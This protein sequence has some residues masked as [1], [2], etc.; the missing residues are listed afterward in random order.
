MKKKILIALVVYSLCFLLGGIYIISTIGASTSKLS[1]LIKLYQVETQRKQLLIRIKNV[2]TDLHLKRTPHSKSVETIIDNVKTMEQMS[3]TCFKCH[4]SEF[5][6]KRLLSLRN[7]IED[8]KYLISRVLTLRANRAR[9]KS[10]D[11]KASFKAEQLL[12]LVD[13]MV[14]QATVRLSETTQFSLN[15]ISKSNA[16]L[17]VLVGLTPIFAAMLGFIFIRGLTNPVKELLMAT[18][19][20]KGGD[21]DHRI[22]GLQD[23]FGEVAESFNEMAG[24]VE[25]YTQRLEGQA[26]ELERAHS[27]MSTFCQVLK[28]IGV[29]QTLEGVGTFL[30]EEFEGILNTQ[31][32]Q[33]YIFSSD[34]NT[35][36][37][38]SDK[39]ADTI[40][41][42]E[43]VQ[44]SAIAIAKLDKR[45][46]SPQSPFKPPLLPDYFPK[47]GRQT[48]IPFRIENYTDG[49]FVVVC[50]PDCL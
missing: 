38:L 11:D 16:I 28:K 6:V 24:R 30:M 21:L 45:I 25:D 22:H 4:H 47:D 17:F 42:P 29:Q 48:I 27:E 15:D 32:M 20:L 41:D 7:N 46:T 26:R 33:L 37:V 44:S 35:L 8:Y 14:H 36:F 34:H 49:A 2:Q 13:D 3:E 12:R 1:N 39:G 9:L 40:E 18:R 43:V 5:V 19:K 10:E 50:T 23:E 31:Y